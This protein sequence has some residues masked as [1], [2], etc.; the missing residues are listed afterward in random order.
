MFSGMCFALSVKAQQP[1][2]SFPPTGKTR[3]VDSVYDA[4]NTEERIGQLFMVAAYSGGSNYNEPAISKLIADGQ[5]GGL[6][7]MQGGPGRQ[8]MLTNKYQAAARVPLL[9]AMDAEWGLGMRLDSVQNFPRQMML[10][11]AGDSALV[12]RMGAAIAAQCRRL[13][14]HI[15]FAPVVDV[16]NNPA[17]PVINVRAFGEEKTRVVRL[18]IAYMR[19]LQDNGVMACAKHF[20]GH[21]DTDAD[22]H[23]D[24]PVIRK[25][26]ARLDTLELYPF[27]ELIRAGVQSVMVA[28]LEIPALEKEV[29]VPTTLSKNTVTG[30]LKEKMGFRG[31]VFTDAMN[32]KGVTKYFNPGEAD[33]RAFLAGNDMLLFS[34][35]VPVAIAK[36]REAL[37]QNRVTQKDL[38]TRVKKILAAKYDAGLAQ[39]QPIKA[40]GISEDLN[41]MIIPLR[42]SVASSAVTLIR[43]DNDILS[44]LQNPASRIGYIGVNADSSFLCRE[45]QGAANIA[46]KWLPKGGKP[47]HIARILNEMNTNTATIVA[48]HRLNIYPAN[49]YG[50]D[51]RQMDFIRQVQNRKDVMIV[52]MGNP[53]FLK[54]ACDVRS[55]IVG[56]EDDSV[57]QRAVA[58]VMLQRSTAVGRLP[59]TPCPGMPAGTTGMIAA[60]EPRAEHP[61]EPGVP[62]QLHKVYHPEDA[63]VV[64]PQALDKLNMFMQRSIVAKAFPGCR[65]LAA[66]DGKVF[67]NESFGY[68]TYEKNQPVTSQTL[69]DVASLTKV[70]STTLAV[71]RLY[72]Q[73]K[74]RLDHTLG[75]YFPELKGT[76][77]ATV[78]VKQLLLHQGGM[79]SWIPFYKETLD[80]DGKWRAD[81]YR[82]K[83]EPGFGRQVAANLYLRDDFK[84]TIWQRIH[85]QPLENK[86]RSVY[87]DLDFYYLAEIVERITKTPIDVYV[88]REFYKPLGLQRILYNP[89][90][91]IPDTLIAPTENDLGFRRSQ[92]RGYVHDQGAALMG[93]V[94]GHAGLFATAND[95]AVI[96]QMLLN[97]GVYKGVRYFRKETVE[98]FTAYNSAIS[99]RALGF[100]KPDADAKNAVVTGNR[101]SG[102]TFG[103]QGFTGTCVWADP[104]TGVVFV[105]LSNRIYPSAENTQINKLNVRTVAQDYIYEALGIPHNNNRPAVKQLQLSRRK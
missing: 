45:L 56:Y 53:Y 25:S 23:T 99:R 64:N 12:Y 91:Q 26:V 13:G 31:I 16:N 10:G 38:E 17:N 71:M 15:N 27:R 65:I 105:F 83:P 44:K 90:Q 28:H 11:A 37:E 80:E 46:P 73:G 104:A 50:L 103:H 82:T 47:E 29:H 77:K 7:F 1:D 58:A 49:N 87:S 68:H 43:D 57:T 102:Y 81:L 32:M 97:K 93:G 76:D 40:A 36:I 20:P 19:G 95:V 84:D 14:V 94:A 33:L 70:L 9:I 89:L 34:Q 2:V 67:Y 85:S 5:I 59:V 101:C 22:S 60:V 3:W 6:I 74:L 69:Y 61:A 21:G 8:A 4:L 41:R 24:L 78:T 72:E 63:G 62:W 92:L 55:A 66:K 35:D 52:L 51:Q 100:D 48:I 18:G 39:W 98:T 88:T 54:N 30:L 86:G 96:F 42:T 75:Q 79:K